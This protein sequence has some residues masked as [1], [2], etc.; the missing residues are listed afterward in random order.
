[1]SLTILTSYQGS[2]KKDHHGLNE[3]SL[4]CCSF[5]RSNVFNCFITEVC[6][7]E[8]KAR[9]YLEFLH[10][11]SMQ[12]PLIRYLRH[13]TFIITEFFIGQ[14]YGYSDYSSPC[15]YGKSFDQNISLQ[16]A[17]GNHFDTWP[18]LTSH[19]LAHLATAVRLNRLLVFVLVCLFVFRRVCQQIDS[20]SFLSS[21]CKL[22]SRS[23]WISWYQ[24]ISNVLVVP[25][26]FNRTFSRPSR[27]RSVCLFVYFALLFFICPAFPDST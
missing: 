13:I 18:S 1:M 11:H 5:R 7:V 26:L 16:Q 2:V 20:R 23:L 14:S 17:C 27:F 9:T 3:Q 10:V 21:E 6:I 12:N 8:Q 15:V 24:E 19:A 4:L 22:F 25:C